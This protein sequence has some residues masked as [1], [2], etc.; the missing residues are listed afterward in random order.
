MYKRKTRQILAK[1]KKQK[2]IYKLTKT[3]ITKYEKMVKQEKQKVI[4]PK[5]DDLL[6]KKK[7]PKSCQV[8]KTQK[9]G[10][11]RRKITKKR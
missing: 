9:S 1:F 6:K 4:I 8:I 11:K 3:K 10:K 2:K 7:R 5:C